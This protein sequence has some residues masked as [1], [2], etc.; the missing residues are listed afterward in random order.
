MLAP[1]FCTPVVLAAPA[2][3]V[4]VG[5]AMDLWLASTESDGWLRATGGADP[6]RFF[7]AALAGVCD[8]DC[9]AGFCDEDAAEYAPA[10]V[11]HP[12]LDADS[13]GPGCFAAALAPVLTPSTGPAVFTEPTWSAGSESKPSANG[14][15]VCK[16][17]WPSPVAIRLESAAGARGVEASLTIDSESA[18]GATGGEVVVSTERMA[19]SAKRRAGRTVAMVAPHDASASRSVSFTLA[20]GLHAGPDSKAAEQALGRDSIDVSASRARIA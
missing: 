10:S 17:G 14:S 3:L 19:A 13:T 11:M 20:S 1:S 8:R 7:A 18:I 4:K 2:G 9:S 5:G 12:P 6:D 16:A 15:E